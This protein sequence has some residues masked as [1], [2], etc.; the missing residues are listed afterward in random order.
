ML[1]G[2]SGEESHEYVCVRSVVVPP[3]S[4]PPRGNRALKPMS[5]PLYVCFRRSSVYVKL[6]AA[7]VETAVDATSYIVTAWPSTGLNTVT[8]VKLGFC[9]RLARPGTTRVRFS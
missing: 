4:R 2:L 6:L 3:N 7:A 9:E 5:N 8:G 1:F